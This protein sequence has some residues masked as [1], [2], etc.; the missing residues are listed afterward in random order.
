MAWL[1]KPIGG[2]ICVEKL[3][4]DEL[5]QKCRQYGMNAKI[6]LR[7]FAGLLPE[8]AKR[9]L[10]RR[11][12]FISIQEFAGKLAGMSEF[13]VDRIL[14]LHEKIKDKPALLKLFESGAEGWSKILTVAYIS[15]QETDKF[16]ADKLLLLSKP[17]LAMFVQN[18]RRK[19]VP[20][21]KKENDNAI[22]Q[23]G[24]PN[25]LS[26]EGEGVYPFGENGQDLPVRFSFPA[27]KEVEFDLRLA[28]QK[29]EKQSKQVLSWDETFKKLIQKSELATGKNIAIPGPGFCS[30]CHKKANIQNVQICD[31]CI[32]Y[33]QQ[34][35]F[36][37]N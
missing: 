2:E 16:W 5:Y 15:T 28:K 26:G 4:D 31:N 14:Q 30:K 13:A 22:S 25:A 9:G 33:D 20:G 17:A 29:L 10:H 3:S 27:S 19:S 36:K 1:V 12:G 8:V 18:Y 24:M 35:C 11:K 37:K 7:K 32:N 34:K 23:A 21:D 6:W